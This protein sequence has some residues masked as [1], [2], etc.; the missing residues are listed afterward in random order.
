M[1]VLAYKM[2]LHHKTR[3]MVTVL[4]I[5]VAFF[6]SAAQLGLLVGWCNTTS[7]LVRHAAV[8]VWVMAPHTPAFDYGTAIP[9]Q[10]LYQVRNVP[11]VEWAEGMF[12]GW[13][14]WQRPDGRR[15]NVELIGL[16]DSLV[17]GPWEVKQGDLAVVH[18]PESVVVDDL[19]RDV[20]GIDGVG[21]EVE[22][23]GK[24]AVVRAVSTGVR[25]FT[26]SPFVFTSLKT[27]IK[28]DKR[29][30]EDEITYVLARGD[31]GVPAAR[32][33]DAIRRE[34][35]NV[36]ALTSDEFALRTMKYWMLETGAGI[37]VVLTA[38]LGLVVA[39]VIISQTLFA[40]TQDHL[41]DY[42]TLSALGFSRG[43][44]VG[45]VLVQSL[46][47]GGA[48][49]LLG[50]AAFAVAARFSAASPIPLEATPPSF[51]ALVA[52]CLGCCLLA[53]G[54]SIRTLF[55]LDPLLVFRV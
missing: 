25:T 11:G 15:V 54:V 40:I 3:L 30:R 38:V 10:R 24:R 17:G 36:E 29:Y 28:Y 31:P 22:M 12:M 50:S 41:P 43:R 6:L 13:N 32:L 45:T 55:R 2:L 53:S 44:L 33:R 5:G 39:A 19:Y 37:T 48:G 18:A 1:L 8:D 21:D 51:A 49:T 16:D 35:P 7:A 20:L 47:L 34:V 26:T 23:L 46:L 42:A 27:A 9:K 14:F 4:G 52:I